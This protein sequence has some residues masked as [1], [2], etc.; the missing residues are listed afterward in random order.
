M[1]LSREE[2]ARFI[3]TLGIAMLI[4]S[5]I[6]YLIQGEFLTFSKVLLIAGGVALVA[7]LAIGY[8][9]LIAHFSKR[10][11]K[12][13]SNTLVLSLAVLAILV[14]AN[15]IA[16]RHP[17]R[18]DLTTEKL[19]SL[20]D[21]STQIVR[22]L[23]QDV[24][25]VRFDKTP[26]PNFDELMDNYKHASSHIQYRTVDPNK[27]PEVAA[28]YG[29]T[30]IGDVVIAVGDH[31]EK[32]DGSTAGEQEVTG[33]IIKATSGKVKTV[34]FLTGHGEKS[35]TEAGPTG[36]NGAADGL[37]KENYL[38]KSINLITGDGIPPD[39][40]VLVD[41]GPTQSFFPQEATTI[42]KFL[43]A[44]GDAFFMLDAQTDPKLDD[45][46]TP[47]NIAV[48]N[49]VVVDASGMGRLFGGGPI[50]PVV[51]DFGNS[52]ITKGFSGSVAFFPLARTVSIANPSQPTPTDVEL[53]KTSARSFTI[54]K[55]EKGQKELKFDEK[56]D[57]LG[58]LSLGVSAEKKA[59]AHT[60]RLVVI[61]NSQYAQNSLITQ[62]RNGDLFYNSVNWLAQDENMM[63]IRPKSSTSR[64][65]TLT[66]TQIA[67][68][69]W[70]DMIFIPGIVL[71]S[72]IYIWFKRR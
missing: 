44:G 66:E 25:V 57:K 12:Q 11:A 22:N 29:A 15:V 45:L 6:R 13:G 56:T 24:N 55:L 41:A 63:S 53:L 39:C 70:I 71:I 23:K 5:G 42:G 32:I 58:P 10:S 31:K 16:Y 19:N 46:M 60:A 18:W 26:N 59:D 36:F 69:K 54:P 1:K 47:W 72:G 62:Q 2:V 67:L 28:D 52:P 14:I 9:G 68:L 4:S 3:A 34:C 7:A 61:G 51:A 50:I 37:Q 20:S 27:N 49:N 65:V 38:T 48:G 30:N 40:S 33:A 64:S 21:Q 17:K 8:K 43:D 35:I